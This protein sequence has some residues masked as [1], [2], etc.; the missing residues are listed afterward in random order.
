MRRVVLLVVGVVAA[1]GIAASVASATQGPFG[2]LGKPESAGHFEG[3]LGMPLVVPT[4]DCAGFAAANTVTFSDV[5]SSG[6]ARTW[7]V[8][9]RPWTKGIMQLSGTAAVGPFSYALSAHLSVEGFLAE[10]PSLGE[11]TVTLTRNDRARM[12]GKA[13]INLGG[14]NLDHFQ[15]SWEET[16]TCK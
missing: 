11:G 1:V 16:P 14:Q 10:S 3:P 6:S 8:D 7:F 9:A 4:A 15:L 12:D 13:V 5:A 2:N